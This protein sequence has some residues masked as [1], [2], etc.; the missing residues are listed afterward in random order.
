MSEPRQLTDTVKIRLLE[1]I[2]SATEHGP[3]APTW[4]DVRE[5]ALRVA[6]I[7]VRLSSTESDRGRKEEREKDK[8]KAMEEYITFLE[9]DIRRNAGFLDVHGIKTDQAVIDK[10]EALR[11]RIAERTVP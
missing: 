4:E 9:E 2:L 5:I 1:H 7:A 10:G 8:Y 6:E 11:R 3:V